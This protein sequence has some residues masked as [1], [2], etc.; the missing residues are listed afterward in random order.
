MIGLDILLRNITQWVLMNKKNIYYVEYIISLRAS[1][2]KSKPSEAEFVE[3][4]CF[5]LKE[6]KVLFG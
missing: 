6:N 5:D 3:L 1:T 2:E 4:F